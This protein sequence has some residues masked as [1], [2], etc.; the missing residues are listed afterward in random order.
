MGPFELIEKIYNSLATG[1]HEKGVNIY[2]TFTVLEFKNKLN[3]LAIY[4]KNLNKGEV[5]N[6][7]MSDCTH[8]RVLEHCR[9][10]CF[11]SFL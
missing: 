2:F 1:F 5:S 11:F 7:N 3:W 6:Q 10:L 9:I 4:A 8:P